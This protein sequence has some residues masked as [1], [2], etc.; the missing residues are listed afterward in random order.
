MSDQFGD[1]GDNG[2]PAGGNSVH[3]IGRPVIHSAKQGLRKTIISTERRVGD[4]EQIR[5]AT[6]PPLSN[7]ARTDARE[8]SLHSLAGSV[9]ND[10][11]S[12]ASL[13]DANELAGKYLP[14]RIIPDLG[15]P[16]EYS[17]K[18]VPGKVFD[19]FDNG[20]FR[21]DFPDKAVVFKPQS[22]PCAVET[23]VDAPGVPG[24]RNVLAWEP[25]AYDI[26]GN[27]IASKSVGCEF[28]DITI[29]RHLGPM[30]RQYAAREFLNLAEGD[31]LKPARA[32][33]TQRKS[34]H[35][36]KQVEDVQLAHN[37]THT[38]KP[39]KTSATAA[40]ARERTMNRRVSRLDRSPSNSESILE[41]VESRLLMPH[42][43]P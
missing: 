35:A 15:K 7:L 13:G 37:I 28:S 1:F 18:S 12:L 43:D 34:T 8:Q 24:D 20:E 41:M 2:V 27:S 36:R 6:R 22:A 26:N 40:A 23:I 11:Y 29:A 39:M 33:K 38:R 10:P 21:A 14:F 32:L 3:P 25:S 5:L 17:V 30:F 9:G 16:P 4:V 42:S 19:V 31:R